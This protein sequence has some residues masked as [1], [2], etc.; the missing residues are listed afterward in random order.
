MNRQQFSRRD[1]LKLGA[2][3]AAVSSLAACATMGGSKG[4]VVVIGGGYGG[5]TAAK[6][7]RLWSDGGIDVTMVEPEAAFVSCPLSNLVLGGS[8]TLADLTVPY[9]GLAKYGV[10]VVR[11]TATAVDTA[12]KQVR[13]ASGAT[14]DYDRLV[15]SPGVDFLWDNVRGMS[16]AAAEQIPHAWK[17]GPQTV[18][19]RRQLEA[20]ADGGV[21][22]MSHPLAPYRCPPGPYERA[23]QIAF[24]LKSRKPKSKL[25]MLDANPDY[26]SKKPLFSRV[27]AEDYKGIVEYRVNSAVS[28]VDVAGKTLV[29][30]LGDRIK[31][32]VL[33]L[34]PP[35]R[36]ANIARDA[37]LITANNRWCE[38][39]WT[40]MESIKVPGVH[41][42][43]DATLS[44]PAMPKS[45]HM[46]NQHGKAAAAAIV[47][48]LNGRTPMPPTMANTCY[49]FIDDRNAVHV[50]S[51]HRWVPEKKTLEGVAGSV[52]ISSQD[53]PSWA[54]EG[55]YAL[56]W[57]QTIWA[58]MLA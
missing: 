14:L 32:D 10:R 36:A 2:A 7:T 30:E 53:R 9:T 1:L 57:A 43:G 37:G 19:L 40:T 17:A 34:I 15:V 47:E 13:L 25:I 22:V 39:N 41:V 38:V 26:V 21:V 24:Y 6:Y 16:A 31:G 44:A 8:K 5:A 35:Q 27:F 28:E 18:L 12:K 4:K 3:G 56:G 11:D 20:M 55:Q 33:N 42:L 51:V 54:L 58:D 49:S 23:C 46:A 45:G 48:L 50:A 29:L 52:G